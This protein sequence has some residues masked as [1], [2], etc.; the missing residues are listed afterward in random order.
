MHSGLFDFVCFLLKIPGYSMALGIYGR[1]FIRI[2]ICI[3][4]HITHEYIHTSYTYPQ[5]LAMTTYLANSNLI[6]LCTW[7]GLLAS[8][9]NG[10]ITLVLD[11]PKVDHVLKLVGRDRTKSRAMN[12]MLQRIYFSPLLKRGIVNWRFGAIKD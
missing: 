6:A 1:S 2:C 7:Q 3:H 9:L 12:N 8:S 4:I 11:A 5:T 10:S